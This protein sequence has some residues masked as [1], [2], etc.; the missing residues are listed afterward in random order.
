MKN[1]HETFG[2]E[3]VRKI[4]RN[5][6]HGITHGITRGITLALT[7][8]VFIFVGGF[9]VQ[10]LWNWLLPTLFGLPALGFWQALGILALSRILFGGMGMGGRRHRR[11]HKGE[12]G[13]HLSHEEREHLKQHGDPEVKAT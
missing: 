2:D 1:K 11:R 7:F 3:M 6:E 5:I 4:N 13:W 12:H 9:A 10:L 8:V